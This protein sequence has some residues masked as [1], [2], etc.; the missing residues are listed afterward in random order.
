MADLIVK[1][2]DDALPLPAYAQPG[3][4]GLDLYSTT[5]LTLKPGQ[6]AAVG[7]GIAIVV[8]DGHCAL[9]TPR[10]GLA[11]RQGLSIV[12]SPGVIDS[13]YRGEVKV[14]LVNIDPSEEITIERGDRIAQLLVVP[15]A[16]V[17]IV[18]AADLPSSERGAGGF[19][20]TG[21]R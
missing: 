11:L 18:E 15:V 5:D 10:S 1:R 2:L 20:S 3:D 4:A 17:R 9:T 13:G 12:N 16:A 8:P 21:T 14:I 19:G 7:C 6:R